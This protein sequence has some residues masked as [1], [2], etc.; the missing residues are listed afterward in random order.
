MKR[1]L[2]T[3]LLPGCCAWAQAADNTAYAIQLQQQQ[4]QHLQ[5]IA[6]QAANN[7]PAQI[8]AQPP[9]VTAP[10]PQP[11]YTTLVAAPQ[12]TPSAAPQPVNPPSPPP[13]PLPVADVGSNLSDEAFANIAKS[14]LPLS[15]GQIRTLHL[16]FD[17]NQR[18]AA[19][20]PGTPPKPTSTSV[21]VNLSPG[22]TPPVIRLTSGFITSMVFLDST[23]APWPIKAYSIGDSKA[24]N[25]VWD[26]E[27]NT[28]L[29]QAITQY[30]VGNL[31]VI[32]QGLNTPVMITLIP[33][34]Q[35]VDYRVDLRIPGLGPNAIPTQIGLPGVGSPYLLNVLDGIPP[36]GSKQLNV[37][38][39]DADIWLLNNRIYVRTRLTILSPGWV[40]TL[41]SA[42]GTHAYE[43]VPAP[44][45][46][47]SYHGKVVK[48]TIE[49]Y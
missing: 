5:Q 15:P 32:L 18:A 34:Q 40:S 48:L 36:P 8:T 25:V 3:I 9:V 19:E 13:Q 42:D 46:L 24:F 14:A 10:P 41:S 11:P 6:N 38:G 16:L 1:I 44:L 12:T 4:L 45:I 31:A 30:K 27:S 43:M 26:K 20:Y 49:G 23:G 39:G 2:L 28:L 47:A 17:A 33:G 22:A 29:V 7:Q 35:A 21:I 37:T